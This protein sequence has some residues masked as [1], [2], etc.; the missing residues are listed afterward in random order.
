MDQVLF[1]L[2]RFGPTEPISPIVDGIRFETVPE[3][4]TLALAAL[5]CSGLLR[6]VRRK[7]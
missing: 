5:A 1:G 2:P 6:H 4:G 7:G 3:P